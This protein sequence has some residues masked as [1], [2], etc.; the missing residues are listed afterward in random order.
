MNT[1]PF[2]R[3]YELVGDDVVVPFAVEPLDIRGRAVQ[4]GPMVDEIIKRHEYPPDI[5]FLLAEMIVLTVLLGTSLKFDGNFILQT[6][7]DGP[8]SLTV[9]D[10]STPDAVRA[11][12]RYDADALENAIKAGKNSPRDLLGEGVMAL[13]VDQG[14]HMQ[15]YQGIVALD[16]ISLEEAAHQYFRQSEQIPTRVKLSVAQVLRPSQEDGSVETL[17]RAGGMIVQ[18]LPESE[19]RIS[20]RDL[21]DGREDSDEVDEDDAWVEATAL[22]GTIGDDE[23]TDPNIGV[24]HLL[25]RLFNEHGVRVFEGQQVLD[26]C[27][28]SR[29]RV[30]ALVRSF[31]EESDKLDGHDS[32]TTQCEFCS[33]VYKIS[34]DEL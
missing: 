13:T 6:Q 17:W 7:S 26:K 1:P 10:F 30:I 33:T 3:E 18:F 8:V 28:C 16:G 14:E 9:V 5:A 25:F 24:E 19:D 15:R 27:S 20:Q 4:L 34:A 23:L 22:V 29:E 32:F 2:D 31:D 21:P 11:Y 12:A